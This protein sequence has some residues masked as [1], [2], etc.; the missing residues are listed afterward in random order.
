M[1]FVD[2]TLE[3]VWSDTKILERG[4][5]KQ[6]ATNRCENYNNKT[7]KQKNKYR[8]QLL[9]VNKREKTQKLLSVVGDTVNCWWGQL[10]WKTTH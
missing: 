7:F 1:K 2:F 5:A 10:D 8:F 6:V 4:A 9:R 3:R